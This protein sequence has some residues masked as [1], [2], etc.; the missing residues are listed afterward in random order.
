MATTITKNKPLIIVESPTK[1]RT[2]SRILGKGYH[3]L[4]SQGHVRDLP[5]K[6][7]GV[8]IENG[9]EPKFRVI[10]AKSKVVRSLRDAAKKARNVLLA[11]DPDR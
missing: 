8:D 3:V 11:T 4:S 10:G 9:Y 2:L 1:A 7:L 5:E 6:E